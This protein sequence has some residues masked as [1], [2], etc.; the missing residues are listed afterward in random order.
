MIKAT[1]LVLLILGAAMTAAAQ[2]RSW[3]IQLEEPTGIERRD[4]EVVRFVARFGVGEARANQLRVLDDQRREIP[5][6]I[7]VSEAH[8]DGSIKSAEILFPATLIPG[9]LP[10]YRLLA[11]PT[12]PSARQP[13]ERGGDYVSDIVVRRLGAGRLEI[14]N[15]RFGIIVN[16]GKDNTTP[17]IVEAYN[18]TS[19]EHRMLNLV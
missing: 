11:L 8:L 1:A 17:A 6:Q 18:R 15:S 7:A 3:T 5:S 2:G 16:L 10:S 12:A 14:G 9:R 13:G 4:N 19:G